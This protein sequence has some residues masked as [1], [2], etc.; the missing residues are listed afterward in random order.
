MPL[1]IPS[2]LSRSQFEQACLYF[3]ES[4]RVRNEKLDAVQGGWKWNPHQFT[5][6]GYLSRRR[7]IF[8]SDPKETSDLQSIES[9]EDE[10][11][12]NRAPP[13]SIL[14]VKEF[15]VYSATYQVPA[16][17]FILHDSREQRR[18]PAYD[19]IA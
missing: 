2:T 12:A 11:T 18:L 5:G 8:S 19:H 15:V 4:R 13:C 17:C 14:E 7:K 9:D 1:E 6:Y 10:A 16:F 3:C